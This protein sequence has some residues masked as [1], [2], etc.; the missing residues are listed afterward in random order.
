MLETSEEVAGK[1]HGHS[2]IVVV[3]THGHTYSLSGIDGVWVDIASFIRCFQAAPSLRDKP[4]IF[5]FQ[6]CRGRERA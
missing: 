2:C 4:K 3:M 6:A 5:I 1:D